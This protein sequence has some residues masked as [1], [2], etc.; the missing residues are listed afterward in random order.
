MRLAAL[1]AYLVPA[2]ALAQDATAPAAAQGASAL[3]SMLPLL[4][5]F[6]VF[7][8][9]LIRP[10]QQRQKELK[11][12]QEALKKGDEVVTAGGAIGKFLHDGDNGTAMVELAPG[13]E[14]KIIKT[15]ITNV[16]KREAAA[17]ATRKKSKG[18]PQVKNDNVVPDK[19]QVAND[20]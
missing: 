16:I 18:N 15:T 2:I 8:F 7:Y 3:T 9:L 5:I 11:T 4:L 20:N 6:F 10:Q 1:I 19:E 13:V 12:M 17:P 14:V